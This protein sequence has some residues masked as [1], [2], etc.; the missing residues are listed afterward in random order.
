M[1]RTFTGNG[2]LILTMNLVQLIDVAG[3]NMGSLGMLAKKLGK[4]QPRISEW[5]AGVRKPD[6]GEIAELAEA[7]NLPIFETV[8]QIEAELNPAH[9]KLWKKAVSELRQNQG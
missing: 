6:A 5:K 1:Y 4:R 2:K 9:A 3:A 7:A 8:A